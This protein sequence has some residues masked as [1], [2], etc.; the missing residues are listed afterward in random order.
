MAGKKLQGQVAIITGGGRGIGAATARRLAQAGASVLLTARTETEI[1]AVAAEVSTAGGAAIALAAD[2][3]DP[4]HAE[5]LVE[6]ALEQ[7]GRVD[8]LINNA[9][10]IHP[11]QRT[12]DTDPDEWYYNMQVNLMGPYY[13][14]RNVLPLMLHQNY[15]RIIN[16]ISGASTYPIVGAGA[17][18]A[19]KAALLMFTR[20][21]AA[22]TSGT[23]VASLALN[24]GMVDTAMQAEIREVDQ[25]EAQVDTSFW[26][27][28]HARGA[29]HAVDDVARALLWLAGP[30]GA[31]DTAPADPYV[32]DNAEWRARVF[33][34]I[35]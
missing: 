18:C 16:V 12:I 33:S 7:F 8:I 34:D 10:L 25:E 4:E 35:P 19:A 23:R 11:L 21:L 14:A 30:W 24:P 13:L 32:F 20:V 3:A 31:R 15:G 2:V 22:E 17:Y 5:E 9:G 27:D 6:S 28:V 26:H 1:D 29:L